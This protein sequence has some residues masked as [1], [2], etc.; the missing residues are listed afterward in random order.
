M[1]TSSFPWIIKDS[2]TCILKKDDVRWGM[3]RQTSGQGINGGG[4]HMSKAVAC[5]R[6]ASWMNS[7]LYV[8]QCF[9]REQCFCHC[10]CVARGK[11]V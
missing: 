8:D 7:A 11:G 5:A 4:D 9:L 10:Y 3:Q 6:R 2:L 1:F